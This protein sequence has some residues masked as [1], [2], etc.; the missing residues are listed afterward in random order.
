MAKSMTSFRAGAATI[1][2]RAVVMAGARGSAS[3]TTGPTDPAGRAYAAILGLTS[4][5][6]PEIVAAVKKGLAYRAFEKF[7]VQTTM[8]SSEA[9]ALV[10]IPIRTLTRRK[11]EGRLTAEE[12]DRLL[13]ASRILG[14][15]IELFDGNKSEARQW[16]KRPQPALGG[17]QPLDMASTEVGAL[18]VERLIGQLEHGVFV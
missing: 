9:A 16:L 15:A 11:Q 17:A 10:G 6:T 13:R 1:R 18:A 12:S 3:T 14:Q 5:Q 7:V 8:S 2:K 4:L